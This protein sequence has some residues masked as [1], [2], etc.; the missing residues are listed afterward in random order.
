MLLRR[1]V[2]H[3]LSFEV[4]LANEA[5]RWRMEA[6]KLPPGNER[7]ALLNKARQADTA[8]RIARWVNPAGLQPPEYPTATSPTRA[9]RK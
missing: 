1:H 2:K 7:D 4:R 5:Q 3:E 6:D 9:S 8:V